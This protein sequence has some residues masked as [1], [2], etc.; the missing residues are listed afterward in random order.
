MNL[1][2]NKLATDPV[3]DYVDGVERFS[4]VADYL[5]VNVSSP[6]T[7][8]LTSLQSKKELKTL[9]KAVNEAR[10]KSERRPPLL[11]KIEPDLSEEELED[12]ADVV[13]NGRTK[14]D[15]IIVSNTT[16]SKENLDNHV[17]VFKEK[18]RIVVCY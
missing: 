9:L 6:N 12:V 5:V 13:Q 7:P 18:M 16:L 4:D 15:G 3:R 1:G 10:A 2:K 8:G 17:S 11:L 14:V